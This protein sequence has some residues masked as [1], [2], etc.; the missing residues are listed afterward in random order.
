MHAPEIQ[1]DGVAGLAPPRFVLASGEGVGYGLFRLDTASLEYLLDHLESIADPVTRATAWVTLWDEVLEGRAQ[2]A[3]FIERARAALAREDNELVIQRLLGYVES[4][5]WR[6]TPAADRSALA[7]QLEELL[8]SLL[9]NAPNTSLKATYFNAYTSIALTEA[10]VDRMQRVWSKDLEIPGL[11]LSERQYTSMAEELAIR[12]VANAEEVLTLQG[13]RI[14]NPDRKA[15]FEFVL[16]AL[17]T[18]PAVREAFFES[19]R[20]PAN[21]ERE[22]WVL[23]GVSFLH[24]PLRATDAEQ[25]I[26]PSLELLQEIQATGDIFFPKRWLDATLGGHSS[27]SAAAVVRDFLA[28]QRRYPDRLRLKILQSADLLFRAAETR[29]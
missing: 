10:G 19:L 4:A 27:S 1:L 21:R 6:F 14:E 5:Y 20:D 29:H 11:P 13:Q 9:E 26:R 8:W 28:S 18:N 12:N 15:R 22:P 16:P 24:H 3:R 2:P 25:L 23:A 7:P 17:S